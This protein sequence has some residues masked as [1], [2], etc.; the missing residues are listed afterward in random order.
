MRVGRATSGVIT[1]VVLASSV[2]GSSDLSGCVAGAATS[3]GRLAVLDGA[4]NS[5]AHKSCERGKGLRLIKVNY[6]IWIISR[7]RVHTLKKSIL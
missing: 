7:E 2:G 3:S 1:L 6:L 5:Y 4:G